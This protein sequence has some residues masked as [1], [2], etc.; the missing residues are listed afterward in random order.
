MQL[1]PPLLG[2]LCSPS[3]AITNSADLQHHHLVLRERT[4]ACTHP[5]SQLCPQAST[6]RPPAVQASRPRPQ[7]Q[8]A[9]VQQQ[10]NAPGPLWM[11][12]FT[13]YFISSCGRERPRSGTLKEASWLPAL[14][15][16]NLQCFPSCRSE[17]STIFLIPF[18]PHPLPSLVPSPLCRSPRLALITSMLTSH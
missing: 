1:C 3:S 6:G 15:W 18:L 5:E 4:D 13:S 7:A 14:F 12:T 9:P 2:S 17:P 11:H 8:G 16:A 10:H